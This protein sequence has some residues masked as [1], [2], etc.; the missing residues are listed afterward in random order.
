MFNKRQ[1]IKSPGIWGH[2]TLRTKWLFDP[3]FL[4]QSKL[5]LDSEVAPKS[6]TFHVANRGRQAVRKCIISDSTIFCILVA[7]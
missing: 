2:K 4:H 1:K 5:Y 3:R 7:K 6:P